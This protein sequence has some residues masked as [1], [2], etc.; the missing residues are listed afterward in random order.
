MYSPYLRS[1]LIFLFFHII[2]HF[3]TAHSSVRWLVSYMTSPLTLPTNTKMVKRY[4]HSH[5]L[6]FR[7]CL[8]LLK[9]FYRKKYHTV[10]MISIS[11]VWDSVEQHCTDTCKY[12]AVLP[13]L[14][15]ISVSNSLSHLSSEPHLGLVYS[16][17]E[18]HFDSLSVDW[19]GYWWCHSVLMVKASADHGL[20]DELWSKKNTDMCII[21]EVTG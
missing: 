2:I 10:Y 3:T 18:C 13:K 5:K 21:P 12:V 20:H 9:P 8:S 1:N 6:F 4:I 19:P 15:F 11:I 16:G 17:Q 14:H 7:F